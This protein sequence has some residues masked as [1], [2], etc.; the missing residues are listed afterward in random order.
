MC[1]A[2]LGQEAD[3]TEH[4][5]CWDTGLSWGLSLETPLSHWELRSPL[6][7]SKPGLG[8]E[9]QPTRAGEAVPAR[10]QLLASYIWKPGPAWSWWP[11]L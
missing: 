1:Q 3:N 6:Y 10:V 4:V 7:S 2:P 5:L 8:W 11:G 9:D